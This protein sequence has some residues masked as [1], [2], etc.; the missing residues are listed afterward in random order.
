MCIYIYIY[1]NVSVVI[2]FCEKTLIREGIKATTVRDVC[3]LEYQWPTN[4]FTICH[5]VRIY[6]S[7]VITHTQHSLT[8]WIVAPIC[9]FF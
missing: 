9:L 4:A 1:I 5:R 7:F 6:I 3:N 2:M 8:H